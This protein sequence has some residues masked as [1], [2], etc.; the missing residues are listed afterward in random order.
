MTKQSITDL[1]TNDILKKVLDNIEKR[2]KNNDCPSTI[3]SDFYIERHGVYLVDSSK[4]PIRLTIDT[5]VLGLI[6]IKDYHG[7]S[8]Q[9]HITVASDKQIDD[10]DELVINSPFESITLYGSEQK[11]SIL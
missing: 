2:Y 4:K 5:K 1:F 6:Y 9:N 8:G 7:T 11:F 10:L 3:N